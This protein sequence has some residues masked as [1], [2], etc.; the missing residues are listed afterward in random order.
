MK[1]IVVFIL[2]ILSVICLTGYSAYMFISFDK[3]DDAE[4]KAN[5]VTEKKEIMQEKDE[6][7]NSEEKTREIKS[8]NNDTT[9]KE[10]TKVITTT[11]ASIK[12]TIS[13]KTTSVTTTV[14]TAQKQEEKTTDISDDAKKNILYR[15][16][17]YNTYGIKIIFKDEESNTSNTVVKQYN[18][19]IIYSVLSKIETGLKKYPSNFFN[20]LKSKY[21]G[22]SIYLVTSISGNYSGLTNNNSNGVVITIATGSSENSSALFENTLHHELMHY[23]DCYLASI[24]NVKDSML[25]MNPDGFVYGSLD[26]AYVNFYVSSES[27]YFL[28]KY[29]KTNYLE[30]R[31]TLFEDMMTRPFK[32][33]YYNEGMPINKKAKLISQQIE[34]Y[35][36]GNSSSYW[37]RFI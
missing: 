31:A 33:D 19:K 20:S 12:T 14:K 18:D 16:K 36:G 15:D 23:M 4:V 21:K 32:K 27:V 10:T 30:D 5:N 3:I 26:E 2:L 37:R 6:S 9:K 22:L 29:A 34:T 13:E 7:N 17:I 24:I 35:I 8:D 11:S 1:R 28:S 25:D